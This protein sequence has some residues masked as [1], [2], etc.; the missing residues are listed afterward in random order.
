MLGFG[1][2]VDAGELRFRDCGGRC[3][4]RWTVKVLDFLIAVV[5]RFCGR[6]LLLDGDCLS[7]SRWGFGR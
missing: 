6:F 1:H 2:V 4:C 7:G 3:R 5:R